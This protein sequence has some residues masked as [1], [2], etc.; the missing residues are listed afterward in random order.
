MVESRGSY[1]NR[2]ERPGKEVEMKGEASG[3]ERKKE[4]KK[5]G[6]IIFSLDTATT[7]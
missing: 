5:T 3:S 4:R 1:E 6:R 2:R 7:F